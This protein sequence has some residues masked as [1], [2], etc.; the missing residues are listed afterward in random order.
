[1]KSRLLLVVAT[2]FLLVGCNES[3]PEENKEEISTSES[4]S[5][6]EESITSQD[7]QSS[8]ASSSD[9][10]SE[11]IIQGNKTLSVTFLNNTAFPKGGLPNSDH[12]AFIEAFNGESNLLAS[13]TN[14]QNNLVQISNNTSDD[15]YINSTLQLG[16]RSGAGEIA[17]T[18]NYPVTRVTLEVQA[19]WT[20]FSYT[21]QP[22][23]YNVDE[24]ANICVDNDNNYIDLKNNGGA[25]PEKVIRSFDFNNATQVK[26][27]DVMD[28][29]SLPD[30]QGQRVY[31]H[32]MEIT[33]VD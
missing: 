26:L 8:E 29:D 30:K 9:E 23:T 25:E 21:G 11:E 13:F 2:A 27:Y 12:A 33:Y 18:F 5:T 7:S 6:S 1:M 14:T 19:Y 10:S 3:Q 20:A 32:S 24:N 15:C 28:C 31:I 22:L 17:F 16:S 4:G